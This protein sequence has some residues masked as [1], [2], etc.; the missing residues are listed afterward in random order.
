MRFLDPH[1]VER[2]DPDIFECSARRHTFTRTPSG[3]RLLSSDGA[4][5]R[6]REMFTLNGARFVAID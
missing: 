4:R 1:G 6:Q 5:A 2:V 3:I